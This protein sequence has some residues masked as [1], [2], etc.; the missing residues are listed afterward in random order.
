MG[1]IKKQGIINS[2][3]LY[4]G[5]G[6]SLLNGVILF[7][8]IIGAEVFG[9][10]QWISSMGM[11]LNLIGGLGLQHIALRFLPHFRNKGGNNEGFLSF[12]LFFA[13]IGIGFMVLVLWLFR[14]NLLDLFEE[15]NSYFLLE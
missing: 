13:S 5:L 15:N 12:L 6:F 3:L 1:E 8:R 11:L 9:F 10:T 7:P 4:I 2:I 14:L